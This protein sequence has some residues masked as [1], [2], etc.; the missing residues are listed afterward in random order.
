MRQLFFSD[1]P[2]QYFSPQ[3]IDAV[4][5][6]L[7]LSVML[8]HLRPLVGENLAIFQFVYNYHVIGFLLLPFLY[9]IK[10]VN[11]LQVKTWTARFFVPFTAF[12]ILYG[13][14]NFFVLGN[15]FGVI[16][17]MKG[18]FIATP[19]M[20]D[21]VTGS[22]ILWFLPHIFLVFVVF[23]IAIS[24]VRHLWVLL[25]VSFIAHVFM[26][27]IS[28]EFVMNVPFTAINIFYLFFIGCILRLVIISLKDNG[29]K[30]AWLFLAVF[31]ASQII[32]IST[33]AVLGYTGIYLF[34]VSE[35]LKLL[36]CDV[37][38]I[39][40]LL[41]FLY[42][43]FFKNLKPLTWLGKHS[44]IVFL[45]HQPFLFVGW[46]AFEKFVGKS[47]VIDDS[48]LYGTV[49]FIFALCASAVCVLFFMKFKTLNSLVFPRSIEGWLRVKS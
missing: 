47:T 45:V 40:G 44:M 43:S 4:K 49:T 17:V 30:Y 10:K 28:K 5:G 3:Q 33:S 26:G 36:L 31:I 21:A 37:L 29:K 14:L 2:I 18:Y 24:K 12:F 42:A 35:P 8:G 1:T 27:F 39:S 19:R 7:I 48:G 15:E 23:N 38:V 6:I 20:V 22:E 34:D 25:G 32:S 13:M 9:P 11:L 41:F 46:K 16:D